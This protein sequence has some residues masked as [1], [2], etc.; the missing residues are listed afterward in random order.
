MFER[1]RLKG[2]NEGYIGL[3]IYVAVRTPTKDEP[4]GTKNRSIRESQRGKSLRSE[5]SPEDLYRDCR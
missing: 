1:A 4:L 3:T 5:A 2:R